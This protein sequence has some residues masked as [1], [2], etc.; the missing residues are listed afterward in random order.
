MSF[1]NE[2]E[3]YPILTEF[4]SSKGYRTVSQAS[5]K[6][7]KGWV[8]DVAAYNKKKK[9]LIAVEAKLS[10]DHALA[11]ISQAE[12]Y[13]MAC[14]KA[15]IAFP[16]NEWNYKT[17]EEKR[18]NVE[19]IC[20]KRGIGILKVIGRELMD[21]CEEIVKPAISLRIDLTEDIIKDIRK[22][23]ESLTGFNEDDFTYF[24]DHQNWKKY[25]VRKKLEKLSEDIEKSIPN[26]APFLEDHKIKT[27]KVGKNYAGLNIF[28]GTKQTNCSH[29]SIGIAAW[30]F[31]VFI[32]IPTTNLVDNFLVKLRNNRKK[33][34]SLIK[35][36]E[37]NIELFSRTSRA[38]HGRPMPG[39]TI[40]NKILD[41]KTSSITAQL[42]DQLIETI[43]N[44]SYPAINFSK[45]YDVE[46]S[47]Y[48]INRHECLDFILYVFS[49]LKPIYDFI[50][51]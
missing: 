10:L 16:H 21:P 26:K 23:F 40:Y 47:G 9:E 34:H 3:M 25:V 28:K 18:R 11:A 12:M 51:K 32:Q 39:Y 35:D 45:R 37:F 41:I 8:I 7:L 5:F 31:S 4:F 6:M 22:S 48:I 19:E 17:N 38:R 24:L 42:L 44:T 33:F 14:S 29:F 2:S 13:Q 43:E 27:Q 50:P 46:S 1:S 49:A 30:F 20:K 15:Y 36:F